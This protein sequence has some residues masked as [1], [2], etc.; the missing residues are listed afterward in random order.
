MIKADFSIYSSKEYD[1]TGCIKF[2]KYHKCSA[3]SYSLNEKSC[4]ISQYVVQNIEYFPD[5]E[6]KITYTTFILF[7]FLKIEKSDSKC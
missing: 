6:N 4:L 1:F 7:D 3:F 2:C 5:L